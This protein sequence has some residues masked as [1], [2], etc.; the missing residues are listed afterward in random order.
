MAA[1]Q[2]V[3]ANCH[4]IA[5][6]VGSAALARFEGNVALT[7]SKGSPSCASGYYHG[8][9]ERAFVGVA[10]KEGLVRVARSICTAGGMRP[11]GFL[12]FQCRHGLG[13]GLMIQTGYDLP[14]SLSVC[15]GLAT[16]WDEVLCSGGAFMENLG[17]R[18][19]FKSRWLDDEEPLYPCTRIGQ[20]HKRACYL[21]VSA[22][23]IALNG[24]DWAATA[25][26]CARLAASWRPEC[27]RGYG[28]DAA[29]PT[30]FAPGKVFHLC[31][32]A[33]SGQGD[34]LYGA[35]RTIAD[36]FQSATPAVSFC[37]RAPRSH[38]DA[39]F[40]GVGIVVGLLEPTD[41]RRRSACAGLTRAHADACAEAAIAEVDPSARETWG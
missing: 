29:G 22:R 18:F 9:L 30:R 14:L 24:I 39:C 8:L 2:Y 3:E 38:R 16:R 10:S 17:T 35:A 36:N 11:R 33:G 25:S 37:V 12:D 5:H 41:R 13:H 15:T 20:R 1:D 34:C 19:G 40:S 28:R 23:I 31:R 6:T 32:V 26:T 7:F 4:G 27:F 21:R